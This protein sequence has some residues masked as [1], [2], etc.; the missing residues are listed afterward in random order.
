MFTYI[1]IYAYVYIYRE[2]GREICISTYM[3]VW[4]SLSLFLVTS[5]HLEL[6]NKV[7]LDSK[8]IHFGLKYRLL[9]PSVPQQGSGGPRNAQKGFLLQFAIHI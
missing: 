7:N 3:N 5:S 4:T 2:R 1:Y 9:G 8:S 6:P